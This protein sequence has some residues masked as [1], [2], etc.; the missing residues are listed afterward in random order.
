MKSEKPVL[1]WKSTKAGGAPVYGSRP[2]PLPRNG[3]PGAWHDSG[4]DPILCERGVH[5]CRTLRQ[6]LVGGWLNEWLWVA[7]IKGGVV[8][9]NDKSA[10][11][12]GRLLYRLETWNEQSARLFAADCAEAVASASSDPRSVDA[13]LATRRFAFGLIPAYDLAAAWVAAR[14]AA[15]A[16]QTLRLGQYLRNEVDLDAI[17][18]SVE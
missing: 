5:G 6:M 12:H 16:A 3:N 10:G 13:I 18:K 17:R 4:G 1:V 7:E 9:G 8:D 11:R 14:D 2:L 15:W